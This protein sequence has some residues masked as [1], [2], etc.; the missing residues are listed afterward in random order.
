MRQVQQIR[1]RRSFMLL[2]LLFLAIIAVFVSINSI[3]FRVSQVTVEGNKY[4]PAEEVVA[5]AAVPAHSNIF[6]IDT[7]AVAKRLQHDLRFA[8]A[9]VS[10][11]LPNAIVITVTERQPLAYVAA[12]YGF[13]EIDQHGVV[14][15]AYKNIKQMGV[16]M[17]T[18]LRLT[19]VYVG[20]TVTDEVLRGV[21]SYLAALPPDVLA[22]LSEV[23]VHDRHNITA[24]TAAGV[25]IRLGDI[26]S[27]PGKADLTG[28]VLTELAKSKTA[29]EYVD[30]SFSPPVI[31]FRRP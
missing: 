7:G 9:T 17:I 19:N 23:N 11:R 12:G 14:L 16:P 24:V 10:R 22:R 31:K 27:L 20:D 13:V 6:R 1:S 5:A 26:A 25:I 30:L 15:A 8:Q 21:L 2:L 18:G 28:N 29:A 4:T 3:F